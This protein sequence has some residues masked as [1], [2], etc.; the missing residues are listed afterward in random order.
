MYIDGSLLGRQSNGCSVSWAWSTSLARDKKPLTAYAGLIT[1][2]R[3][4][5][6]CS[7]SMCVPL[8]C[9]KVCLIWHL[10]SP[11]L[12]GGDGVLYLFIYLFIYL[13]LA[14]LG[15]RCCMQAFSSCGEWELLFLVV[16]GFLIA[17]ASLVV[18]H[19]L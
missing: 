6:P 10:T 5:I 19:G 2:C 15:L 17:V 12:Q 4:S 9:L 1:L 8:F 11:L 16:C 18:E 14:V 3:N 7:A 13:M